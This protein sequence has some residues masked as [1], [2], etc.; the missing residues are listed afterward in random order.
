MKVL[1]DEFADALRQRQRP[2]EAQGSWPEYSRAVII[3]VDDSSADPSQWKAVQ[4]WEHVDDE[5]RRQP[6]F[7]SF[8]GDADLLPNGNVLVDNGGIPSPQPDA[9][10]YNRC[11]VTEVVPGDVGGR[12]VWDLRI[13]TPERPV[14]CYRAERIPGFYRN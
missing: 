8:V 13:G 4:T 11:M 5:T 6:A 1:P 10:D 7:A 12:V 3:R 2:A 9:G 14:I